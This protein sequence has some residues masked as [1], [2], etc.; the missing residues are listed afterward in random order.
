MRSCSA[1]MLARAHEAA[2]GRLVERLDQEGRLAAAGHAG[3]G[4]EDAERD[5]RR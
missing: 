5:R 1:G 2:R 3:D 4:G